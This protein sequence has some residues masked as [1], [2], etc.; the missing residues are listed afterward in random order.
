MIYGWKTDTFEIVVGEVETLANLLIERGGERTDQRGGC[1][2]LGCTGN[3]GRGKRRVTGETP[4]WNRG[5]RG[6]HS[7]RILSCQGETG[8]VKN[9]AP[10]TGNGDTRDA[11][12]ST[13]PRPRRE[14]ER[15]DL[16]QWNI[17]LPQA[18]ER[19]WRR[20]TER[21]CRGEGAKGGKTLRR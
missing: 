18:K 14:T 3:Q 17:P 15:E 16:A 11:A 4:L 2:C 20:D 1:V 10:A 6:G 5:W 19:P 9:T 12:H 8:H 7:R 21:E 13:A